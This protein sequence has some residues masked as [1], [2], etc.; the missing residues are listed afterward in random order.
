ML[1]KLKKLKPELTVASQY[2]TWK[3]TQCIIPLKSEENTFF[4]TRTLYTNYELGVRVKS[5]LSLDTSKNLPSGYA[6]IAHN[7][8]SREKGSMRSR[9][10]S[11]TERGV[12]G[13][14]RTTTKGG[15]RMLRV[16]NLEQRSKSSRGDFCKISNGVP[17]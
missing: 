8:I 4:Q 10:D 5:F 13:T 3:L 15:F 7:S 11:N 2:Q 6:S 17:M 12:K 9:T 16:T 14:F 1:I